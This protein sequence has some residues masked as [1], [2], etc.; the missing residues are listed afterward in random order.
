LALNDILKA[1][2]DKAETRISAI[3]REAELRVQEILSEVEKEAARTRRARLKKIEDQIHSEATAAVYSAQLKAKN[4]LI[5]AQEE[6]VD[7]AFKHAEVKLAE[8]DRQQDYPQVLEVLL[9]ECLE[10]FPTGEV[11]V[12]TRPQDRATVEKMLTDRG[13]P[14]RVSD[15]P[16]DASGG[17]IVSSPDG[18]ITVSNTFESRLERARDHLRLEISKALFGA[19]A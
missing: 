10:F 14:Y 12:A 1:L 13:R 3:E 16:L 5:K 9:D 18:Q 8:L 17:L 7:E 11:L 15:T 4:R 2:E 19:E 6:T